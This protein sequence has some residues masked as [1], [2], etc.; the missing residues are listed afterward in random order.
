MTSL[1]KFPTIP[2]SLPSDLPV[3]AGAGLAGMMAALSLAPQPCVLL[4]AAPLTREGSSGWA[5]G[6]VAAAVGPDDDVALQVADTLAA[7]DGLCDAAAVQAIVG[8]G[9][10]AIE[11]LAAFGVRFDR[12]ADGRPVLGLEAAHSRR[13]IVHARGD[14]T[15]AEIV[16]ALADAVRATASITVVEGA[17]LVRLLVEDGAVAG[18]EIRLQG[19]IQAVRTRQVVIATGGVGGLFLDTTNPLGSTGSGLAVAARAGAAL[20]DLE[21]VQFHPTALAVGDGAVGPAPRGSRPMSLVSEAVRGEGATLIDETGARFMQNELAPRDVV[22][23]AVWHHLAA[24]HS[25]FL[26]ARDAL[27]ER[28]ATRFPGITAACLA[29]DIDPATMPIP[30][31]PAAHYHMGGIAVDAEGCSSLPGLWACGEA[32]CTGLHGANRLASNS[33]LEAAVCGE[34]VAGSLLRKAATPAVRATPPGVRNVPA[35]PDPMLQPVRRILSRDV[36]VLRDAAGLE[37]AVAALAPMAAASD[38]ALLGLMIA[39]CALARCESR[40]GHFRTDFPARQDTAQRRTWTAGE[41]LAVAPT[42][43]R[44]S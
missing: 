4:S 28:F 8:G 44:A 25:V 15:G 5:Q 19:R 43:R 1:A 39:Q 14:G 9:P 33:L 38:A 30:I 41:A 22:S 13:R 11:R 40:G 21:F 16:R 24:G 31:R 35:S 20:G 12:D 23:R 34:R 10:R 18:A 36:G 7:G 3:I 42:R 6:G 37:R 17:V 2:A 29:H 26:D 27:G 32:A